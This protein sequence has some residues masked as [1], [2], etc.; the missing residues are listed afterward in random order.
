M[1]RLARRDEHDREILALALPAF[2]AL[3]AEPLYVLVDTAIVGRLGTKP[4]AGLAVAGIVLTAVFGIFNF[5]AY[6][7]TGAVARRVG[8][9]DR[10]GAAEQGID[11][12]WLA[13]GLG[14]ALAVLGL[15][16]APLI[17]HG[18]GA[19]AKVRPYALTYLRIS[20]LGSPFVLLALAGAG[21]QRGTQDT[22]TTLVI[23]L[24]SNVANL[25]IELLFV[26]GLHLGIAGS[27]WGT[28]IAQIGAAAAYTGIIGRA[29]RALHASIAPDWAGI[30]AA[31]VVGSQLVVRTG[32]LLFALL[33][34]T[35]IASRIGDT[36][37]AAHQVAYEVWSFLA[38][39]LD[40]IAIAG[41]ALVGRY[42]GA[43]DAVRTRAAARRMLE[44]GVLAGIVLAIA[45]VGTR[46]VLP[47]LF[48]G[49]PAVRHTAGTVLLI[50]GGLQPLAAAVFVLDGILIGAGDTRYLAIAMAG[51]TAVYLPAAA[52]VLVSHHGLLALWGAIALWMFARFAG[53]MWRY[54]GN[55]WIVTGATR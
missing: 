33:V 34:T 29:V 25:A 47:S 32:S 23:A 38:L 44:L 20:L 6:G 39:S 45:V 28:V 54:V 19:S 27:A 2:G 30:R 50:V 14:L 51:A 9:G 37:V 22:R 3:A 15:V 17:V 24:L 26:Y 48:T 52:L 21:Y 13:V 41:Q 43:D 31:A 53:M 49:D 42:L 55:A 40:A 10:K 18:M 12:M 4:L 8:A 36:E 5:L 7:T 11:G 1:S 16:F 35:A 46:T